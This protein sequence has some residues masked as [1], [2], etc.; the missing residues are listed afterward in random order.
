MNKKFTKRITGSIL[1]LALFGLLGM[2]E[3]LYSQVQATQIQALPKVI[4]KVLDESKKAIPG[5]KV[6]V[7][8]NPK[9]ATTTN[10]TGEF[11]LS[12]DKSGVTLVFSSIGFK[13]QEVTLKSDLKLPLI[14]V[15]KESTDELNEVVVTGYSKRS[16]ESFTGSASTFTGE[17]LKRVGNKN[18]LQS[19]QNLDPSFVI[20]ENLSLGSNPN[21][22]PD[23]QL[24]GQA[25]LEDVRGDYS[26]NPNLPLF[27]LDGFESSL[28]KI[29]DLDMNRVSSITI[30]RDASAK[31]IY[32]SKAA[33]GVLV[34]ETLAPKEGKLRITYNSNYNLEVPDLTSY[35]LTNAS[36]KLQVER[37]AG[38]YTSTSP[39]TQQFLTEQ[40]NVIESDI[41][42]GVNTY[43]L[44][45]PLRVGLG[46]KHGLYLEGGDPNMRYGI[47]LNYNNLVG[48]MKD[49]K[50]DNI[51]GSINLS[52]RSGKV[53]FRNILNLN[54]NKS[55]NSP[56]G[57]F[58]EYTR[59]NPYWA[60]TDEYGRINKILGEFTTSAT[61]PTTYY[62]NPLYNATLNT[63]DFSTYT[64]VT[65]N[66]YTEWQ[67]SKDLRI[68][69][70]VGFTQNRN[71]SE[72]FYPGDH[73]RFNEMTGE[74][75]YRR[76]TY[77][78]TDGKSTT[79]NSDVFANWN[80]MW[81]KHL[82]LV[83]GGGNLGS[84][85]ALTHG[86]AAEGFLNNRVD[87]ITFAAQYALNGVPSGSENIQ[88]E[89]GILASAN[90][91]YDNRYLVDLSARRNASSVFGANNRWGTFWSVGLGWNLHHESFIKKLNVF[92]MLKI[93]GSIGSTGSQ[94][95]NP[96]QAMAT[97]TF[98]TNST[99]DNI[100]GT[101][102]SAL[103]NNNLRWQEKIDN[104]IGID[105]SVM[106]RLNIRFDYYLANTNNLLTDLTLPPSTGFTT[107][108]ENLGSMQNVGFEG[109]VSYQLYR[110]TKTQSYISVFGSFARNSNKITKISE[111]LKQ[112]NK[113]QD[114]L[115]NAS[116][117][118]VTRFEEGQSMSS[119]W[120]VP[121]LGI[122]PATGREIY[123]A[124]DGTKTYEWNPNDQVVAGVTDPALRGNFGLNM[125]YRGWGL[126]GTFRYA[127]GEDYYNS[128]LANRIENVDIA[129][130][131]DTRV[132][133]NTWLN[134][135]DRVPFKKINTRP[136]QTRATTRFIE[137]KSDLTLSSVNVYYDFKW[138]NLKRFG[139]QNLK[140]SLLMNEVFVLSTIKI[141]RGTDYPFARTFSFSLQTTF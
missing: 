110:D 87:F 118:P 42:R 23:I 141:E 106:K 60:P 10:N 97:Y 121:S 20:A 136:S 65:E 130:N 29:Y 108:K 98:F 56:Y 1:T 73:T 115:A 49:S 64:E 138:K 139:L 129:N 128:T 101:Y 79:L 89:V 88:R 35:S 14:V 85:Q 5:V 70:R 120:A 67:P 71:A 135:G 78:M 116:N 28:Q 3:R 68:T 61:S 31:A 33:N 95:F 21:L 109:T 58:G 126:S 84:T 2:P 59:L 30:L 91:A 8:D 34:I 40:A 131:V 25:G 114:Q 17:D 15:L 93:R 105:I 27:I 11:I 83:T 111:G 54:F 51:G 16:K 37:N 44:S 41:A 66:F 24:R 134:V 13:R 81:G 99:Y 36:E 9:I 117:A 123:V 69:G 38:R 22:L 92:D 140:C 102:L 39:L 76:G 50:R 57:T 63:K 127:I 48:V 119:I 74:N 6:S 86:M 122:D 52:Y 94:N 26:G 80:K 132:F 113:E 82:L 107:Y 77:N 124:K 103:A 19:L 96:Y 90:Y 100:S 12:P 46:I 7:K 18:V 53:I 112:L 62:Y 125:E 47:D 43:W 32:G 45:K 137:N 72:L 133:N 4:G 75:F 104:N 55:V